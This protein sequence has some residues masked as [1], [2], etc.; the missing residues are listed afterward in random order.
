M[1]HGPM[2]SLAC[3]EGHDQRWATLVPSKVRDPG[4]GPS[5]P[6]PRAVQDLCVILNKVL[7]QGQD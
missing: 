1:S 4:Q 5:W 7:K 6:G 2:D 3:G